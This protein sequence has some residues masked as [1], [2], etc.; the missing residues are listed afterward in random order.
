MPREPPTRMLGAHT[1]MGASVHRL[2]ARG[3]LCRARHPPTVSAARLLVSA[4]SSC[5]ASAPV[6][7]G[8]A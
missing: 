3:R 8:G 6:T 1:V 7:P 2:L 4:T 5:L